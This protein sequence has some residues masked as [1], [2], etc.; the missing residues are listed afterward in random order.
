[1]EG[2]IQGNEI[3]VLEKKVLQ[4]GGRSPTARCKRGKR[5]CKPRS[6][7]IKGSCVTAG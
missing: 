2:V 3:A 4:K 6:L 1:M 7:S 5:G